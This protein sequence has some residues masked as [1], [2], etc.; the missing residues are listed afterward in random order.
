[1]TRVPNLCLLRHANARF[2]GP[3]ANNRV[4]VLDPTGKDACRAIV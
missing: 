4:R 2:N 3:D 1:M